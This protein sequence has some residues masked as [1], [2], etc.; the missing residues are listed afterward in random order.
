VSD[1]KTSTERNRKRRR[2]AFYG[3]IVA[4]LLVIV[5]YETAKDLHEREMEALGGTPRVLGAAELSAPVA[6]YYRSHHL[7]AGWKVGETEAANPSKIEVVI[8]FAPAIS[9]SRHGK[10]ARP[11]EITPSNACLQNEALWHQL[12]GTVVWI[13]VHDKTGLVTKFPCKT[14]IARP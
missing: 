10:S 11:N 4:V 12:S 2:W 14:P 5:I 3:A 8:F 13:L 7:P 6:G 9:S 1:K